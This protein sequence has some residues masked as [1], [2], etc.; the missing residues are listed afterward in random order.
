MRRLPLVLM[1][2]AASLG[3]QAQT[4]AEV[5]AFVEGAAA[6]A[7]TH[8]RTDFLAEVNEPGGRFHY[9]A[10][11]HHGLYLFVYDLK[12]TVLAHGARRELVGI[13]RWNARDPDGRLWVQAWTRLVQ[14]VGRGW[15]RYKELNPDANNR[16]MD[17]TSWVELCGDMVLGAGRYEAPP[18]E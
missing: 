1:V 10:G 3:L 2:L 13:N 16:W 9:R 17:K 18:G 4:R 7:R 12:G 14:S 11:V 8:D 5:R 15:T 6:Y